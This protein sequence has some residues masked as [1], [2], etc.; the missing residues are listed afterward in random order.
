[1]NNNQFTG[2]L[3]SEIGLLSQLSVLLL[4]TNNLTMT[5]PTTV[6]SMS[7]LEVIT[8]YGNEFVGTLPTQLGA[9]PNLRSFDCNLNQF[10]G[11]VPSQLGRLTALT[12][13]TND[14]L[15]S[16]SPPSHRAFI[17]SRSVEQSARGI[18]TAR[19][20]CTDQSEFLALCIGVILWLD[21]CDSTEQQ[22]SDIVASRSRSA[23]AAFVA[24][25]TVES[26][27]R[28]DAN[29]VVGS[30]PFGCFV[31]FLFV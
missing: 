6:G 30:F 20:G 26:D 24:V 28:I 3:F 17:V 2:P 16:P 11:P 19:V 10:V 4:S 12:V 7:N 8:L 21:A 18:G 1:V 31:L 13:R 22:Q 29:R 27:R 15:E 9:V 23:D 25:R 14:C 5:L